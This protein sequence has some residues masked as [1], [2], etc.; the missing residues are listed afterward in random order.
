[1]RIDS[2]RALPFVGAMRYLVLLCA[3]AAAASAAVPPNL[4]AALKTF[5]ADTPPG[6]SFTQTTAAGDKSTVERC[7]AAKPELDRWS[8][9]QQDGR[10]PTSD[11][12]GNYAAMRSRRSRGGTAPK[13]T[14]QLDLATLET[15]TDTLERATFRCRLKRGEAGDKTSD[16]LR[17]KIVLHKP[18]KTIE[19]IELASTGE[20]SPTFGVKIA[21]MST[22]LAY[23]LPVGDRPSL[24]EKVT[25]RVRG[26]AFFLKS[27]DEEMTVT[28]SAY[29][30]AGKK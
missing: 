25:T 12:L 27:L 7:D 28:F 11:E 17:A 8:L 2:R 6:W 5:R 21:E 24:P 29:E 3:F 4:A 15:V 16:F 1:M 26:R 18:T 19:S 23:S 10:T 22:A 20:F 30:R 9:V 13:L 14:D